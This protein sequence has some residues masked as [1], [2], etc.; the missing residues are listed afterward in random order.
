MLSM[1]LEPLGW[2]R[3]ELPR[4]RREEARK[5]HALGGCTEEE[6]GYMNGKV[7]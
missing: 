3:R 4:V 5:V 6:C 1:R 7:R 2:R